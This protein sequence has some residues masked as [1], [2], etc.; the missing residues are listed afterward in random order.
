MQTI[1]RTLVKDKSTF[2]SPTKNKILV[3]AGVIISTLGSTLDLE[4]RRDKKT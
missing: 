2:F 1:E 4:S 3:A